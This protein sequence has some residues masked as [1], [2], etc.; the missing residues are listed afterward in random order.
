MAA[1]IV[2]AAV[3]IIG[4]FCAVTLGNARSTQQALVYGTAANGIQVGIAGIGWHIRQ[5]ADQDGRRF[6]IHDSRANMAPV[7]DGESGGCLYVPYPDPIGDLYIFSENGALK[8]E[9]VATGNEEVLCSS[10]VSS[11]DF[12][13][14]MSGSPLARTGAI[15]Y[16]L[17][18]TTRHQTGTLS[19]SEFPR[20]K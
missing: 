6:V 8:V 13:A 3:V 16:T 5:G 4:V 1:A 15:M 10:G 14:E 20:N 9:T 18:T 11:I 19:C 2:S 17:V 7:A 12:A